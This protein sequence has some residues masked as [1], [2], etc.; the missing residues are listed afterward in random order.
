MTADSLARFAGAH[1]PN[2]LCG[3]GR[4]VDIGAPGA[5]DGFMGRALLVAT[6][7]VLSSPP[8]FAQALST[9]HITITLADATGKITPVARHALL[10]SEEPPSCGAATHTSPRWLAL[11]TSRCVPGVMPW[12]PISR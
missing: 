6:L 8:A 7:L 2:V 5:D 12:S 1:L 9:L 10:I 3:Y 4:T 11:P